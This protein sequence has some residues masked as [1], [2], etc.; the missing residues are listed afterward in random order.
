MN[1]YSKHKEKV[2]PAKPSGQIKTSTVKK[3]QKNGDIYILERRTIYDPEKKYNK[4]LSTK[5]ISKIPKGSE[6]PVPTRPKKTKCRDSEPKTGIMSAKRTHVGMMDIINHIGSVSG[7]DD[8]IYAATDTGT[9]QKIISLARY[10]LATN[11]QSLPGIQTWQYNHQLPYE[12]GITEDIYHNLF[13]RIGNDE[14]LQQSF[15]KSR[16]SLLKAGDALAYDS[17][18]ISTYSEN[19]NEARYGFNKAHDGLK[20]IKL[21]TLY[22]IESRQPVAFTKQPGNLPDVTSVTNA[23]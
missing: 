17:S 6:I 7:I 2:M 13:A 14:S 3:L 11:G 16:C 12:D 15:F 10:L 1:I 19:Q 23:I 4:V 8:A 22:S 20:T 18:T 21:L 9:A 5:L